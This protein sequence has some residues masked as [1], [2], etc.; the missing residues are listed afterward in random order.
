MQGDGVH[1]ASNDTPLVEFAV[2]NRRIKL[3]LV[4]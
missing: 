1:A 4:A 3:A 2:G